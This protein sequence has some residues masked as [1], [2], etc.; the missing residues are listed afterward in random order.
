MKPNKYLLLLITLSAFMACSK[1]TG[2]GE[3]PEEPKGPV[4][5]DPHIAGVSLT[6]RGGAANATD[7]STL[8]IYAVPVT[9]TNTN[10]DAPAPASS[11][12]LYTLADGKASPSDAANTLW[13]EL[14]KVTIFS[15]HPA[16]AATD[17]PVT[18]GG[19]GEAPTIVVPSTAITAGQTGIQ[20]NTDNNYDFADAK[21]DY[22]YGVAYDTNKESQTPP[23]SPFLATQPIANN[24]YA[25]G[26]NPKVNECGPE[27]AIG[28]KHAF[29][30]IRFILKKGS[31]Y[32]GDA[33]VTQV[34]YTRNL[35]TL[36]G[37]PVSET[38]N[39]SQSIT[40]NLTDGKLN[41]LAQAA[42]TTYSYTFA[43]G[44]NV[45]ATNN[46]NTIQLTNYILPNSSADA[47]IVITVDGKDMTLDR[48][49]DTQFEAGNIYT[50]TIQINP[51]GLT[52]SG[53][54]VV[55][56][57]ENQTQPDITI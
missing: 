29:A 54:T 19:T 45:K 26:D 9:T 27:V 38:D 28:L 53:F 23:A 2:T 43:N 49:N 22:M 55:G 51:T 39:T 17:T 25:P 57:G 10:A 41:N 40:M 12:H 13:L 31:T 42:E 18:P 56:W 4:A 44:A 20:A 34:T 33:V 32:A 50:Y 47:K 15:F 16:G 11:Y 30:Q 1:E 37:A 3:E 5:L 36:I 24:G 14:Y 7:I 21:N 35:Q 52:L 8:G 6:T 46:D 48:K